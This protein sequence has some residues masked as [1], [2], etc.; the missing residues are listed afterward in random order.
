MLPIF[1]SRLDEDVHSALSH[2][3]PDIT[4]TDK[5]K[6]GS[7]T[8]STR[9][10]M[11][12]PSCVSSSLIWLGY[13]PCRA[14]S[15]TGKKKKSK[16]S[17]DVIFQSTLSYDRQYFEACSH[18]TPFIR[19]RTD[20]YCDLLIRGRAG[21]PGTLGQFFLGGGG[22]EGAHCIME[23][24]FLMHDGTS[25]PPLRREETQWV[26]PFSTGGWWKHF[27]WNIS[28]RLNLATCE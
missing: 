28:N 15:C 19:R 27:F 17:N 21:G 12:L 2:T 24:S 25:P 13:P 8:C 3:F 5:Q 7:S 14:T 4:P 23:D 22:G 11:S 6:Q 18:V 10:E 26:S 1:I 16:N 20:R 9:D